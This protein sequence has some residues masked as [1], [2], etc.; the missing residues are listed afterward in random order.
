MAEYLHTAPS[1][2]ANVF[3]WCVTG[4]TAH[5]KRGVRNVTC[6]IAEKATPSSDPFF[7]DQI[8][9]CKCDAMRRVKPSPAAAGERQGR[10]ENKCAGQIPEV[11]ALPAKQQISFMRC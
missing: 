7:V 4:S 2:W 5:E 9:V 8:R 11:I 3:Y 6:A 1:A 10:T